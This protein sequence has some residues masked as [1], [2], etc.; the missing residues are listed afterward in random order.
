MDDAG[1]LGI[2]MVSTHALRSYDDVSWWKCI[3]REK[4]YTPAKYYTKH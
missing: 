2:N 3:L 4:T 1:E